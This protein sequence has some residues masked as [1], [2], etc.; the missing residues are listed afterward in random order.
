V[1]DTNDR[2]MTRRGHLRDCSF[3]PRSEFQ[4]RR[5]H[6]IVPALSLNEKEATRL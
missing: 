4:C 2:E 6:V 5:A 3:N 1:R